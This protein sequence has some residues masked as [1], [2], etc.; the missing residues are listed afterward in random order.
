MTPQQLVGLGVRLFAIWLALIS[1]QSLG[2][3][4]LLGK[5]LTAPADLRFLGLG[6]MLLVLVPAILLWMF[7]M[8]V[9]HKLVPRTH[10]S[11]MLRIPARELTAA[12]IAILGL[13]AVIHTLPA[14]LAAISM[15][16]IDGFRFMTYYANPDQSMPLIT[17]ACQCVVGLILVA[18]P[19]PLT[20]RIFPEGDHHPDPEHQDHQR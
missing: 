5:Q 6:A 8:A 9:A 17:T 4:T 16:A 13:W 12:S 3:I 10:D 11:N 20:N 7:P 15:Y 1:F 14:L 2:I 19:W 18:A